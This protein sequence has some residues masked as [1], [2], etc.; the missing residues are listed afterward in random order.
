[1]ELNLFDF[2]MLLNYHQNPNG[3]SYGY[4]V[5]NKLPQIVSQLWVWPAHRTALIAQV[6]DL[7]CEK[8]WSMG[9]GGSAA[10]AFRSLE[11]IQRN[12]K[13]A[14]LLLGCCSKCGTQSDAKL[15]SQ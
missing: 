5:V 7:G 10:C 11:T 8:A 15:N 6:N 13:R 14:C 12:V 4:S 1:M 2:F 3:L 9:W